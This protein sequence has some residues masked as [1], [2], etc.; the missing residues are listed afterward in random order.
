MQEIMWLWAVCMITS[1]YLKGQ[2][3]CFFKKNS[4][5]LTCSF[6]D[7][8]NGKIISKNVDIFFEATSAASLNCTFFRFLPTVPFDIGFNWVSNQIPVSIR[9]SVPCV[10]IISFSDALKMVLKSWNLQMIQNNILDLLHAYYIFYGYF[11]FY[12]LSF[13]STF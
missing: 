11:T 3:Q 8:P 5:F 1:S 4:S 10:M 13:F 7:I 6:G 9:V 2:N 12:N